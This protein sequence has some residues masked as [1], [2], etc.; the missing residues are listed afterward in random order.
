MNVLATVSQHTKEAR[1]GAEIATST[2]DLHRLLYL[3]DWRHTLINGH[4][5]LNVAWERGAFSPVVALDENGDIESGNCGVISDSGMAAISHVILVTSHLD[6]RRLAHLV[7]STHPMMKTADGDVIDLRHMATDYME[8]KRAAAGP[9]AA[10]PGSRDPVP[11][12]V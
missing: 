12:H 4:P 3:I 5:M 11:A 9:H 10:L 8:S 1:D 6:E 7:R 2:V